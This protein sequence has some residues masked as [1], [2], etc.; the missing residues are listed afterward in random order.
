MIK[1]SGINH[2]ALIT[3]DMNATV[4]FYRD[5]IGLPLVAAIGRRPVPALLF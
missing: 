1:F 4:R 3:P 5:V 2:L